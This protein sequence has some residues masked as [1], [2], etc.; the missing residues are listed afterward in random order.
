MHVQCSHVILNSHFILTAAHKLILYFY[1][2]L[3]E[4][5]L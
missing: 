2:M 5:A 4:N 1:K 3:S